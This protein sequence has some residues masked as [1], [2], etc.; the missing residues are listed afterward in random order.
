MSPSCFNSRNLWLNFFY[1]LPP[2]HAAKIAEN[3][4]ELKVQDAVVT[5]PVYFNQVRRSSHMNLIK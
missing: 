4:S 3:F 2:Q 1:Y 5:V